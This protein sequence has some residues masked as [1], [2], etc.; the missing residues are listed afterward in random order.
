MRRTG[1]VVA[2]LVAGA[3]LPVSCAKKPAVSL[4]LLDP[5]APD[6]SFKEAAN[7]TEITVFK[8]GCP[9][10]ADLAAGLTLGN[11]D[12]PPAFDGVA[13]KGEALPGVGDLDKGKYGFAAILRDANCGV[14]GFGCT[15][16]DLKS[17][18]EVR[19][20][21]R[22]W[23]QPDQNKLCEPLKG[24]GCAAGRIC[25]NGSCIAPTDGGSE[26]SGQ[27]CDLTV[28]AAGELP[29]LSATDGGSVQ[30][31]GPVVA[32]SSAGFVIGYRTQING[33][34][35][36]N[37]ALL[38]TSGTINRGTPLPLAACPGKSPADGVGLAFSG[39]NGLMAL[40]LP[41]CDTKG[42]G[43]YFMSV[44]PNGKLG[45][46]KLA[47][48]PG[49]FLDLTLARTHSLSGTGTPDLYDF[50]YRATFPPVGSPPQMQ[51]APLQ[52]N[53][54]AGSISSKFGA[55]AALFGLVASTPQIQALLGQVPS[56]ASVELDL[57]PPGAGSG[58]AGSAKHVFLL[59]L[60][61][62]GAI[63]AW[64]DRAAAIVPGAGSGLTLQAATVTGA[65]LGQVSLQGDQ[66][67]SGDIVNVGDHLIVVGSQAQQLTVFRI[68]GA[69]GGAS[70]P[71]DAGS[72]PQDASTS[73]EAGP[74]EAGA[75]DAGPPPQPDA[76]SGALAMASKA[77]INLNQLS[78]PDGGA[79]FDGHQVSI[80]ATGGEVAIVWRSKLNPPPGAPG[81]WV[82]LKCSQ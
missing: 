59:P 38:T 37:S 39:A 36:A 61:D 31:S 2:L 8:K 26:G 69:L 42:A 35:Y 47:R 75:S 41:D 22:A 16:A 32:A 70:A 51:L 56:K 65:D 72:P 80:A 60:S 19:I 81:G 3:A 29:P 68:D 77:T 40:A 57:Q 27:G 43:A 67:S 34:L 14:I 13:P 21:V 74:S 48:S 58:D 23:T 73:S 24:N 10:D 82:L 30:L 52:G 46:L 20:A 6:N 4:V 5:C 45:A 66:Y 9:S 7:Y 76:G 17:I 64:G 18:R 63:T 44:D 50:M 55:E 1:A 28:K 33:Q 12:Y 49:Q 15:E 62:W 53:S 71:P 54:F 25:D 78:L 11:T 79:S